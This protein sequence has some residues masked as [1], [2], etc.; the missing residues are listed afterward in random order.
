MIELKIIHS[1]VEIQNDIVKNLKQHRVINQTA[2]YLGDG[3]D[4]Y[5][6]PDAILS[7]HYDYHKVAQLLE[8]VLAKRKNEKIAIVS[9]GCGSCQTDK[10]MLERLQEK[11]AHN[12]VF[13]GVDSSM[14]M[15]QKAKEVLRDVTFEAHLI[16]ADFGAENFREQLK[17][18]TGNYDLGIYLLFGGTFSNLNQGYISDVLHNTLNTGDYMLLDIAG[19]DTMTTDI[20]SKLFERYVKYLEN[21]DEADFFLGPLKGFGVPKSAG[22]LILDIAKDDAT[23][24]QV[25]KFRFKIVSPTVFE[26]GESVILSPN[27]CVDLCKIL[28]YDLG[29]L[30]KFLDIKQFKLKDQNLGDFHHQLLFQKQ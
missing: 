19:F 1:E 26:L 22:R 30:K 14:A 3:V 10:G 11:G 23:Q 24:A 5:Y 20:L 28:I 4:L 6:N 25:F 13:F 17:K 15:I 2:L 29:E 8:D 7:K 12:I 16:C 27:E 18:I 9:L 21:P